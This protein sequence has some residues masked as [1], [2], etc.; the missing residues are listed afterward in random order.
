MTCVVIRGFTYF[1]LKG[2]QIFNTP[3]ER[4]ANSYIGR[5]LDIFENLAIVP[6]P[7]NHEDN[8]YEQTVRDQ[9]LEKVSSQQLRNKLFE[10]PNITFVAAIYKGRAWETARRQANTTV[11]G[12]GGKSGLN[13]VQYQRSKETS[14]GFGTHKCYPCA[15]WDILHV[16]RYV[17]LKGK[18]VSSLVKMALDSLL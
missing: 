4:R 16:T 12:E 15:T 1:L 13:M 9:L 8:V 14:T 5:A 6:P 17:Q 3:R 2:K 11:E 7:K 10:V 18:R